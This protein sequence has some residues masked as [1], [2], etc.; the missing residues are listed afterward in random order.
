MPFPSRINKLQELIRVKEANLS[1]LRDRIETE[2]DE[3]TRKSLLD[4][5]TRKDIETSALQSELL[6]SQR[7]LSMF[8][9]NGHVAMLKD[10]IKPRFSSTDIV[11]LLCFLDCF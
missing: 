3:T 5:L 9:G 4:E 10:S 11:R 1:D 8:D 7:L 6:E 2:V